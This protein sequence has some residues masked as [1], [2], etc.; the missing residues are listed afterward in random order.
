MQNVQEVFNKIREM[1]K[2]QKDLRD[3][4][5]DA[6]VQ[7]DKYEEIVEEI[8]VLREKKKEIEAR[9]QA[10]LGRSWEKLED[11]KLEV[12]THRE[13]MNDV[14]ISTL[15]KGETVMVKDEFD[16]AYE[17]IWKVNFKK[18]NLEQTTG[19]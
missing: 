7:A 3:M 13:M 17:P 2:E 12:E 9:I 15:M 4:Y 8:K 1:K 16:N 19:E 14:A 10:Q 18:T 6:L 11:L 5:K